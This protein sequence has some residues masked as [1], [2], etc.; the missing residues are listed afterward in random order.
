M[1]MLEVS[2]KWVLLLVYAS[3]LT[4]TNATLA[5]QLKEESSRHLSIFSNEFEVF[6]CQFSIC[7]LA[8]DE[9]ED[10]RGSEL[11]H[12]DGFEFQR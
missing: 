5:G 10:I 4:Q 3:I 12:S 8:Q 9:G 7:W 1:G 2:P 6:R 11:S